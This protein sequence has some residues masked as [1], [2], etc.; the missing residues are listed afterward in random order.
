VLA[1]IHR[2]TAVDRRRPTWKN[3]AVG[4]RWF[5]LFAR[6]VATGAWF[7]VTVSAVSIELATDS[8]AA[9]IASLQQGL[10]ATASERPNATI[11]ERYRALEPLIVATHNLPYIAEFALRRQWSSLAE[12]D[13]QR[14]V[15]AFE[16]LSVMTYAA[17][18]KAVSADTFRAMTPRAADASGRVQVATAVA[19]ASQPDI[20]LEYLLQQDERDWRIVNIIADGVSDLALKRAEYQRLFA[21]GGLEGLLAELEA[22][23]ERLKRN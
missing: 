13:R 11:D 12:A 18:F 23:T 7:A 22:Q 3:R 5:F 16:R 17:R 15:A 9:T 8:P 4:N 21:S 19:R 2:R 14:F 1:R 10:V 20:S 6:A